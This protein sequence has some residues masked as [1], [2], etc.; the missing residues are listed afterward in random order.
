MRTVIEPDAVEFATQFI[1]I[2]AVGIGIGEERDIV[3]FGDRRTIRAVRR[4]TQFKEI[5][6]FT[7][8]AVRY[9]VEVRIQCSPW[10][11]GMGRADQRADFMGDAAISSPLR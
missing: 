1:R 6:W 2:R 10:G 5:D 4:E 8:I 7:A 9:P 11:K 3:Q